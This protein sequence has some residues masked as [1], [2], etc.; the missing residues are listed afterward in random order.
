MS[1]GAKHVTD[2]DMLVAADAL[3]ALVSDAQLAKGCLY[4]PLSD[5]RTVS[6]RLAAAVAAN[7]YARGDACLQP[8]PADLLAH[9][10]ASMYNPLV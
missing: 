10:E 1:V 7:M 8:Q 5:L 4:P 9:C 3:A 6:A 2:G